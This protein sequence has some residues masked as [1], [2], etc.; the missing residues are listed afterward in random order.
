MNAPRLQEV[1]RW[2]KDQ[3]QPLKSVKKTS[4]PS[5]LNPQ[6]G[7]PGAERLSVYTGGYYARFE[8]SL[9]ETFE[10]IRIILGDD[11]FH[12]LSMEYA[13]HYPSVDYNLSQAGSHFEDFLKTHALLQRFPFLPDLARLEW[14]VAQAFHAHDQTPLT[15]SDFSQLSLE[16]WDRTRLRFQHSLTLMSSPWPILTLWKERQM[17]SQI[18]HK[19]EHW[20]I[21]RLGLQ[22]HLEGLNMVQY[23]LLSNLKQGL[24]LGRACELLL[25]H[26]Q[27]SMPP[28]GEWFTTWASYGLIIGFEQE[29]I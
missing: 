29:N 10:V 14:T 20:L 24:T 7:T 27:G 15:S 12:A 5:F 21:V 6:H 9:K 19:T 11:T 3:I 1:Q 18:A 22:V 28:L 17:A 8:E 13:E 16:D 23:E 26:L 4:T 25:E 2:M